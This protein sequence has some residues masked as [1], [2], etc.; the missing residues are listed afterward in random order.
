LLASNN[1]RPHESKAHPTD[2]TNIRKERRGSHAEATYRYVIARNF[3]IAY[4][5]LHIEINYPLAVS[6]HFGPVISKSWS[7]VCL[8]RKTIWYFPVELS[9]VRAEVSDNGMIRYSFRVDVI[10]Y[11]IEEA[12]IC[13]KPNY[14]W[15]ARPF[16][17]PDPMGLG[18]NRRITILKGQRSI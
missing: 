3:D 9:P 8:Y 10:H 17:L 7:Q 18:W 15:T 11:Q 13:T 6:T 14:F 5:Y 2:P 16:F 1:E 4:R 12:P